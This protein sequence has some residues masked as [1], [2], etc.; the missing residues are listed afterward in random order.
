M[1]SAHRLSWFNPR[2]GLRTLI[3][4]IAKGTTRYNVAE[5]RPDGSTESWL[6]WVY[7]NFDLGVDHFLRTC[8]LYATL[9]APRDIL[10]LVPRLIG[11]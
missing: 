4:A 8:Q 2:T 1:S 10:Y 9:H 11:C 3:A 6:D 5:T 7:G